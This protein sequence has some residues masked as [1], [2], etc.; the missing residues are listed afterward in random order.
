MFTHSESLS[1]N[2]A[3]LHERINGLIPGLEGVALVSYDA[4]TD[5][6]STYL[7]STQSGQALTGYDA[8][9]TSSV[10]LSAIAKSR[11]PRYVADIANTFSPAR[12]HSQWLLK[13]GYQ[14]SLTVPIYSGDRFL[15]F[16]F[17][18]SQTR[19]GFTREQQAS[20]VTYAG[21]ITTA[22]SEVEAPIRIIQRVASM[23]D[24]ETA[25]HIRRV[26]A[27]SRLIAQ[28]CVARGRASDEFARF[29]FLV[30]PLHDI[31]K[32]A[33]PDRILLKPG[34]LSDAEYALMK[35]HVLRGVELV[36]GI[37]D[38]AYTLPAEQ[39]AILLN[40]V[41]QHHEKLD[42]TGYPLGL[43]GDEISLEGRILAV[44]DIFDALTARRPYKEPWDVELALTEL[45]QLADQNK[46]DRECV[47][48][49]LSHREGIAAI[50]ALY[51]EPAQALGSGK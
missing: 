41:G 20:L 47:E 9:L 51:N 2:L 46:I 32:I 4:E 17:F 18:N 3:R 1:D 33:I 23:R 21:L 36:K 37:L 11:K 26:A 42:G 30:A 31:G 8:T 49:F 43:T 29:V 12:R 13:Q 7:N 28:G 10:S 35:T 6:L 24:F 5:L 38:D 50:M 45:R 22:M 40:I 25:E 34:P 39:Q 19:D 48:I 14:T 15:G 27:Y 44:A 16:V